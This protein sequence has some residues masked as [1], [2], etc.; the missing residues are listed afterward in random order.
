MGDHLRNE[1]LIND[2]LVNIEMG[3]L[4]KG[5]CETAL[6]FTGG[7]DLNVEANLRL[8]RHP[9]DDGKWIRCHDLEFAPLLLNMI[10]DWQDTIGPYLKLAVG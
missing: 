3:L 4:L 1:Q 9:I 8:R 7:T 5:M 6:D 10:P 2:L